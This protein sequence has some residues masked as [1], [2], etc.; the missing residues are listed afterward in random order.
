[1]S[2]Q[3]TIYQKQIQELLGQ[4]EFGQAVD[5]WMKA[6]EE[7]PEQPEALLLLAREFVDAGAE[8]EAAE[9]ISLVT[10]SLKEK[11]KWSELLWALK[12]L[13]Q[14]QPRATGL[15][16]QLLEAY[17]NVFETDT[18]LQTI[19]DCSGLLNPSQPLEEGVARADA[20][21]ALKEGSYCQ[22]KSWGFGRITAF[23]TA[24]NSLRVDF[25]E[26]AG[27]SL[28]LRYAAESV[29]PL[30]A[31]H[32]A[33]RKAED[34]TALKTMAADEPLALMKI[35][36]HSFGRQATAEQ[37]EQMLC[38]DVIAADQ[39]KR[40]WDN[41]KKLLKKDPHVAVPAKKTEPFVLREAPVSVQEELLEAFENARGL[42]A[43]MAVAQ[44]LLKQADEISD[45][46]LILQE[47]ASGLGAAM[48]QA[49]T[50]ERGQLL[51]AALIC[52]ELQRHQKTPAPLDYPPALRESAQR[53]TELVEQL[54]SLPVSFH[55]H[56][57][58][59]ARRLNGDA[60]AEIF[61]KLLPRVSTRL[62]AE[63]AQQLATHGQSE[64][65][66]EF[67]A[68]AVYEQTAN[69]DW[70]LWLGK[71]R[72]DPRWSELLGALWNQRFFLA[73]LGA[74]EEEKAR[75][76]SVRYASRLMEFVMEDKELVADLLQSAE[77]EDVRDAA[78]ALLASP[79]LDEL[80]KR[81]LMA[82]IIKLRPELQ[83]LLTGGETARDTTLVVSWPSYERR[84]VELEEII[85][86]KIPQNARD[87]AQARSYGDL[88][89]NFEFKAA[90]ETQRLLNRR[91]AELERD[92]T[93]A[94]PSY[95]DDVPT[96]RVGIGCRVTVMELPEGTTRSYY[97]LGA[98]DS[99]PQQAIVSYLAPLGQTLL[100]KKVGEEVELEMEGHRQRL[101]IE[102]VEKAPKEILEKL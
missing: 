54:E 94:R 33:V 91:R 24:L 26:K 90:K 15:R 97:I 31:D 89:E 44:E 13:A 46:E 78:R 56:G 83:Q 84:R 79:A 72:R 58:D 36:L 92:L 23:D 75:A 85:N 35:T 14:L 93:S 51:H 20:L 101:R 40:W 63:V 74:L 87:I 57:V 98:W 27:H 59:L 41:T 99:D 19:L 76:A 45:P 62:V 3:F 5:V 18:R 47:F 16:Q 39:W 52:E 28:Q 77:A 37:I 22:H 42:K 4:K 32:I 50:A 73:I 66:R 55:G 49:S 88:R 81:S 61:L 48:R 2:G 7:C 29:T 64:R 9:L 11:A 65:L 86:K 25:R 68:N 21:F 17:Q 6:A 80:T 82:R 102:A 67:T 43:R 30:P 10:P 100:N 38:P 1:M 96:D 34:M 71:I 53:L 12:L 70:L 60:W 8:S 95:F 69:T